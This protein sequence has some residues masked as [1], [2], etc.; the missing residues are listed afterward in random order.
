MAI[1]SIIAPEIPAESKDKFLAAW[2]T[3]ASD[4]TAQ[5]NVAG[6]T[7][8]VIVAEDGA[9][10]TDF[11]FVHVIGMCSFKRAFVEPS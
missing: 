4:L 9:A 1:L 5:P 3:L 11:K 2:P 10:V 7:G 8:G 6:T